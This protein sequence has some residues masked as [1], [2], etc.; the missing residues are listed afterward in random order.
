VHQTVW[1]IKSFGASNNLTHQIVEHVKR[2][3]IVKSTKQQLFQKYLVFRLKS[4]VIFKNHYN[5]QRTKQRV[6]LYYTDTT[7]KVKWRDINGIPFKRKDASSEI[8]EN[9]RRHSEIL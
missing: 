6:K 8:Y 1:C 7:L 9:F 2:F 3:D 4:V 5:H